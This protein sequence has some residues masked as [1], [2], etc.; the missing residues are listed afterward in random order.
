MEEVFSEF[1]IQWAP[2]KRRGPSRCME[3]LGM[4]LC[5]TEVAPRCIALSEKRQCKLKA[6]ISD[7][8]SKRHGSG[9]VQVEPRE[10]AQLLGHLVFA[11]QCV[12]NGRSF[13]QSMLSC[14]NP[15]LPLVR[16]ADAPCYYA[17]RGAAVA[18]LVLRKW[19]HSR[20]IISM[21]YALG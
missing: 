9:R 14:F 21:M 7:W 19:S 13:M 1:G 17:R 15:S 5:N 16:Q 12:P 8:M 18:V 4:L 11:A 10:L 6:M 2:W 20:D 3:F